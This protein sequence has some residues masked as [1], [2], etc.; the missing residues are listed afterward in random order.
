MLISL[1]LSRVLVYGGA[2]IMVAALLPIRNLMNHLAPGKVRLSWALLMS[3]TVAF[4]GG[5]IA[6]GLIFIESANGPVDLIVPSIFFLGGIFVWMSAF[7]SLNTATEVRRVTM[8]EQESVTDDLTGIFNRRYLDRRLNEEFARAERFQQALAILW[9]DL[10]RF[11][12]L[13]ESYGQPAGDAALAAFSSLLTQTIR[14]SDVVARYGGDEFMVIAAQI[15]GHEAYA[16]AERIRKAAEAH[17]FEAVD[18]QKK[19]SL[20]LSTSIGVACYSDKFTGVRAFVDCAGLM[21][22]Q[23]KQKGRN[24]T[25]LWDEGGPAKKNTGSRDRNYTL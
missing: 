3:F 12:L 5:Y 17:P 9:I 16:L 14:A 7:L 20:R 21:L 11:A 18:G 4:V 22:N 24:N 15:S 8:L 25:M 2:V 6:Y 1:I 19:I 23:A 13:N 10:D